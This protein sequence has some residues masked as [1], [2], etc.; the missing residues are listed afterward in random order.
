MGFEGLMITWWGSTR[1][2]RRF[3]YAGVIGVTIDVTWQ[4]IDPLLTATNRWIVFGIVGVFLVSLA[5][6][7]ERRLEK[8]MALTKDVRRR[9]ENWE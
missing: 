6:I 9:L 1:R 8:V 5:I 7:V 4:L 2:L 3:L